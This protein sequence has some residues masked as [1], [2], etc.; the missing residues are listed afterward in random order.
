[1]NELRSTHSPKS[2]NSMLTFRD[3]TTHLPDLDGNVPV[4]GM[5]DTHCRQK[6]GGHNL[7]DDQ[8][9]YIAIGSTDLGQDPPLRHRRPTPGFRCAYVSNGPVSGFSYTRTHDSAS[10]CKLATARLCVCS[11]V[12]DG[13]R[14]S[15]SKL[16]RHPD[17]TLA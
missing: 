2:D 17:V 8:H 6:T 13:F 14:L 11:P 1:M 15:D 7:H 12:L 16:P 5:S 10:R 3:D 9:S 4:L